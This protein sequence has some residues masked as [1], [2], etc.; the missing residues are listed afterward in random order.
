MKVHAVTAAEIYPDAFSD[1][2]HCR[3][4]GC[5]TAEFA[6]FR[7]DFV[8]LQPAQVR[9]FHFWIITLCTFR[10]IHISPVQSFSSCKSRQ[11]HIS[12]TDDPFGSKTAREILNDIYMT[13]DSCIIR[14]HTIIIPT[15]ALSII[16]YFISMISGS[17]SPRHGASSGCGWRNGLQYG[18]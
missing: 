13:H 4:V 10:D 7:T 14:I 8:S 6:T 3:P 9:T 15:T 1:V 11:C 17:L 5:S 16:N 18:G 12:L 2:V